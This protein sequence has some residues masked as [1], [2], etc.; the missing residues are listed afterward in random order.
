VRF[1]PDILGVALSHVRDAVEALTA[2]GDYPSELAF[3]Y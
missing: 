3:P 2:F 1:G